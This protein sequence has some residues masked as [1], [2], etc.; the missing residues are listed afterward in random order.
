M[1]ISMKKKM[2]KTVWFN[3]LKA[4]G[5][6]AACTGIGYL[7][8]FAGLRTENISMIYLVGVLLVTLVTG[9][10]VYGIVSSVLSI[11]AYNF[12]FTA[13][14][15]T[16]QVYDPNYV[17]TL[18]ILLVGSFIVSTLTN[19]LHMHIA[20]AKRRE[21]QMA[22]LYELSSGFLNISGTENIVTHGLYGLS[23]AQ[24]RQAIIYMGDDLAR[25]TRSSAEEDNRAARWCFENVKPCGCGTEYFPE[26]AWTYLPLRSGNSV[27]GVAGV[28]CDNV[29]MLEE[30]LLLTR[31]VVS[32]IS[33]A[34]ERETLYRQEAENKVRIEKEQLR[35]NLLRAVS[36]DLRTPLTGIAGSA[37]FIAHSLDNLSREEILSLVGGIGNDALWLNNMVENLLNMTRI[38]EDG[39]ALNK[40]GEVV[41]DIVGEAYRR[42]SRIK[43]NKSIRVDVPEEVVELRM[44]GRLIIQ[45]LVNLLD[46]ALKHTPEG[47]AIELKAYPEKGYMVFEVSDNGKGIDPQ[48][49]DKVFDNFVTASASSS[50]AQRGMGI[51]LGICKSIV[52]AHGGVIAALNNDKGG[53]TFK[54]ALPL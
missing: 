14:T 45:V 28:H 19:K 44:D 26:L 25:T 8:Q 20:D 17:V 47:T 15:M 23:K 21:V 7:F 51:G 41:D 2:K 37:D 29:P 50:D 27:F 42:V 24:N 12:F 22:A 5:I 43:T 31:M 48:I 40:Q 39:V 4:V 33:S 49:M 34:L 30:E 3:I 32:Q 46:N 13:P 10:L 11:L 35:N 52:E 36:H 1:G 6:L 18:V 9:A 16:L 38:S 53:A 54:F